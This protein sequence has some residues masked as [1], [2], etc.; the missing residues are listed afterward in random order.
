MEQGQVEVRWVAV[1]P[2]NAAVAEAAAADGVFDERERQQSAAFRR[3]EDRALYQVAHLALR[4]LLAERSGRRPEE[5]V[6]RRAPCPGCGELHGRPEL[7]QAPGLEFSLS[8]S[9]GLALIALAADPIGADVELGGAFAPGAGAE[10]VTQLH[11]AERAEL[12]ELAERRPDRWTAGALRCWVRKEAYLKGTG[13][14]LGQGVDKDYVGLGPGF[15]VAPAG[16]ERPPAGWELR[17]VEV[18]AGYDAAIALR[19]PP[20]LAGESVRVRSAELW[21]G[22]R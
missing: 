8:H 5:V 20:G 17:A 1:T 22:E 13:M 16:G 6:F 3:A 18:P 11:P 21:V 14:G 4:R 19:L 12:A 7:A 10:V 9:G 2:A 15:D